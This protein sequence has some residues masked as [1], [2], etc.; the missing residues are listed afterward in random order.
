[1][2]LSEVRIGFAF[3]GSFCSFGRV[4]PEVENLVSQGADV[5]AIL[6][7][8]TARIDTRFG[9]AGSLIE[10]LTGIT[11]KKPIMSIVDAEPAG[12]KK[13]FDCIVIAPCT[14]NTLAKLANAVTDTTVLMACKAHMRNN[15]PVIIA[16]S[17]NDGLGMNAENL[18]RLLNIKNIYFV[19]FAQDDPLGKPRSIIAKM[20]LIESTVSEALNGRQLQPIILAR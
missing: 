16:V 1:M 17:T 13:L 11:G 8:N 12:P 9:T 18:G 10:R 19:P 14:G 2:D 5:T 7:E 20:E 15:R 4:M 3:T 6:S